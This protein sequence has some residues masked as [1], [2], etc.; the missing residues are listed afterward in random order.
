MWA[1]WGAHYGFYGILTPS[2]F[3]RLSLDAVALDDSFRCADVVFHALPPCSK[4]YA[5]FPTAVKT[6]GVDF[7]DT[8]VNLFAN[9]GDDVLARFSEYLEVGGLPVAV[10][11][12]F[13][14]KLSR[15][16]DHPSHDGVVDGYAAADSLLKSEP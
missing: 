2:I 5:R 8:V 15:M 9:L 3:K 12:I 10:E 11:L 4:P 13:T 16:L 14:D 1:P 6:T 7:T